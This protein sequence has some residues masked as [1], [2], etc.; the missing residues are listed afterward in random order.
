MT[1][2]SLETDSRLSDPKSYT[3]F[4]GATFIANDYEALGHYAENN[5]GAG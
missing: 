1:E 3:R 4:C 5:N 2:L